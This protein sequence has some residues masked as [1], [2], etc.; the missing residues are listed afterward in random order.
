MAGS[1]G[2]EVKSLTQAFNQSQN[3]FLIKPVY[4]GDYIETLTS[5][6]ASFRAHRP[7][8]LFKYLKWVLRTCFILKALSSQLM[9]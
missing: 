8:T 3:K 4:K 1:L 5:F 9:T 7:L 2:E 6:A